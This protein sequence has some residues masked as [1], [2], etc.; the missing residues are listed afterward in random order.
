MAR[1]LL[2]RWACLLVAAVAAATLFFVGR[3]ELAFVGFQTWAFHTGAEPHWPG[4]IA[5][6]GGA[7]LILA[8]LALTI[9]KAL[10]LAIGTRGA[11]G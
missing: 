4:L 7:I 2:P 1:L 3:W 10:R 8:A 6:N 11:N 5:V 9:V